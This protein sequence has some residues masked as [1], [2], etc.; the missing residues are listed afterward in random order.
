MWVWICSFSQDL[1]SQR[2][3]ILWDKCCVFAITILLLGSVYMARYK[4]LTISIFSFT[5]KLVL[6]AICIEQKKKKK[7]KTFQTTKTPE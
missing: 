7:K 6:K 2:H 4:D 3:L 5:V 1:L